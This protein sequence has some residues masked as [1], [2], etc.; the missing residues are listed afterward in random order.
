LNKSILLIFP[1]TNIK[2]FGGNEGTGAQEEKTIA[3]PLGLLYLAAELDAAGYSVDACDFNAEDY[4]AK[5]LCAYASKA[6]LVGISVL[7]FN[8]THA[9]EII[10]E[11]NAFDSKLPL[12]AGGPDLILHPRLVP[13][14]LVSAVQEAEEIIVPLVDAVLGKKD[15]SQV[16]GILYRTE[17]GTVREGKPF[18]Y[19]GNLDSM[20]F[21]LRR[22]LRDN[23]GY[24]ILGRKESRNITTIITSR[25][26]PRK[27]TFCA[28]GAIAYQTYRRRSAENVI[29]EFR[30]IAEDGY[31][32]VGIVDDNFTADKARAKAILKGI[33]ELNAKFTIAVQGRV[34]A[35]DFELFTL[36]RQAGVVLITFGLESGN[37]D[38]LDFYKKGV[39]VEQNRQAIVL[40]DRAGLYTA[41][42]FMLGAPMETTDH[43]RRT[44]ALATH[45]PLDITSFWILDYTYG[46]TLWSEA[47]AKGLF[48]KSEFNVPAG[49]E[50]GTSP[51]PSRDIEKIG[52]SYFFRFY[53]RPGYWMRQVVKLLRV[54][55]KYFFTILLIGIYWLIRRK[56]G[57]MLG[58]M[59]K[60][61][62]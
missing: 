21:P 48:P 23:K 2:T 47:H 39:T 15:L 41:G 51:Y 3:P 46:S 11:L 49:L 16:P 27:C 6:D 22:V 12:I 1:K 52:E 58:K 57:L 45:A 31:R 26:C 44:F 59:Y 50:H 19:T 32:V 8:R 37:Q 24:S 28:H 53:L 62:S 10:R 38:V 4:S 13:G 17:G 34:D 25:G 18:L 42:L 35:A 20:K 30:Q 61:K 7:S 56:I 29:A 5:R 9:E 40:A 54:R 43:F 33:I 14:T 55:D 60:A 36:M